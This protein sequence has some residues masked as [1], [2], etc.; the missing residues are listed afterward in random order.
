MIWKTPFSAR[1][2]CC[3][4]LTLLNDLQ[5]GCDTTVL[6]CLGSCLLKHFQL[7]IRDIVNET[8]YGE[9]SLDHRSF[10]RRVLLEHTDGMVDIEFSKARGACIVVKRDQFSPVL[11][12]QPGSLCQLRCFR[13]NTAPFHDRL[14]AEAG[15]VK[16]SIRQKENQKASNRQ[17]SHLKDSCSSVSLANQTLRTPDFAECSASGRS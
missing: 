1:S 5:G 17:C 2:A 15:N 10:D 12:A 16:D 9:A 8:M 11:P 4:L 3:L 6:L 14:D 7:S 13:R